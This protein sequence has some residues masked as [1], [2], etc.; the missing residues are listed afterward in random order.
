MI[1]SQDF[2]FF[3]HILILLVYSSSQYYEEV[4]YEVQELDLLVSQHMDGSWW[5]TETLL[6]SSN[7][8]VNGSCLPLPDYQ[9]QALYDLYTSTNGDNWV[10][11]IVVPGIPWNFTTTPYPD[12]CGDHW[13]GLSCNICEIQGI[14]LVEMNLD[15]TLPQSIGQFGSQLR[16]LT[17]IGNPLLHGTIPSTIGNL[18]HLEALSLAYSQLSGSFPVEILNG[19]VTNLTVILLGNNA[20]TGP[21]PSLGWSQLTQLKFLNI[22]NNSFSGSIPIE[23]FH[24]PSLLHINAGINKLVGS[25][26]SNIS[27]LSQ[28]IAVEF[29][30]NLLEGSLPVTLTQ[31]TQLQ[32]LILDDNRLTGTVFSSI[33]Q[34]YHLQYLVLNT[35][36]F[37]GT[38]PASL[39]SLSKLQYLY[40]YN[41]HFTGSLPCFGASSTS[42]R[43]FNVFNNH[44]SGTLPDNITLAGGMYSF[45]IHANRFTGSLPL[46]LMTHNPYL[47]LL[48]LH[49][50]M[51]TG[52]IPSL[53]NF[54]SLIFSRFDHNLFTGLIPTGL[55]ATIRLQLTNF[56]YNHLHGDVSHTDFANSLVLNTIDLSWNYFTGT[57]GNTFSQTKALSRL[58]LQ[59]NS[60]S[61]VID[62]LFDFQYQTNLTS[63][64]VSDNALEGTIPD[65]FFTQSNLS[66][67]LASTNCF[68]AILS[69]TMCSNPALTI[70]IMDG[71]HTAEQCRTWI[72]PGLRH[73]F[74]NLSAYM[75]RDPVK[76]T[77]PTCLFSLPLLQ[78]LHLSGNGI[79]STLPSTLTIS[80]SL[81]DLSLSHN[82]LVGTIPSPLLDYPWKTLDLSFNRLTGTISSTVNNF[83]QGSLTLTI[84]R[85]SGDIPSILYHTEDISVLEG[86]L[87]ACP[88]GKQQL[89]QHDPDLLAYVCGSDPVNTS[90]YIW[91]GI[92]S[93]L[94]I[95]V[96]LMIVLTI[97]LNRRTFQERSTFL[98]RYRVCRMLH[99]SYHYM[100]V[101]VLLWWQVYNS[102]SS[103]EYFQQSIEHI[104]EY[105]AVMKEI[106]R[107]CCAVT[108][109][110]VVIFLP[111]YS[112]LSIYY[113]TYVHAY[114]WQLSVAFLSGEIPAY[115]VLMGMIVFVCLLFSIVFRRHWM[116]IFHLYQRSGKKMITGH[117]NTSSSSIHTMRGVSPR[118]TVYGHTPSHTTTDTTA[119]DQPTTDTTTTDTITIAEDVDDESVSTAYPTNYPYLRW[120]SILVI[121][122]LCNILIVL[123]VNISYILYSTSGG[124]SSQSKQSLSFIIT[125]FKIG[126][127][128]TV[129]EVFQ[130]ILMKL[131]PIRLRQ[132]VNNVQMDATHTHGRTH[133]Q[134]GHSVHSSDGT[135]IVVSFMVWMNLFNNIIAPVIAVACVS[136]DCF[137]YAIFS[138]SAVQASFTFTECDG[139]VIPPDQRSI[140]CESYYPAAYQSDYHPAFTYNYQC[141]SS[142]LTNFADVMIYRFVITGFVTP[143]LMIVLKYV[144]EEVYVRYGLLSK[145]YRIVAV[146]IPPVLTALSDD[147]LKRR[148]EI[149]V[150]QEAESEKSVGGVEIENEGRE[151]EESVKDGKGSV[152][153][154]ES[155]EN[156]EKATIGGTNDNIET[157]S[158]VIFKAKSNIIAFISDIAVLLTF[159]GIF[160]PLAFIGFCGICCSTLFTQL[161]LARVV[162]LSRTQEAL[163]PSVERINEKCGGIRYIMIR[164]LLSLTLLLS[165]FWSFFLF[166]ILGDVVG[167]ARATWIITTMTTIPG[168]I[169]LTNYL[170]Q[171]YYPDLVV[172]QDKDRDDKREDEK[173]DI[174][175]ASVV[176]SNSDNS[177]NSNRNNKK[178]NEIVVNVLHS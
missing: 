104:Y 135:L 128:G 147:A 20:L 79:D 12:P 74:R 171:R 132:S 26:P 175:L 28:L 94:C 8:Y 144:Q 169:T 92:F 160:P 70:L 124:L 37:H 97:G 54:T 42:I 168:L 61:G 167:I 115:I 38:I 118:R 172:V 156:I 46:A 18:T 126:W 49:S 88:Q 64:D 90:I 130:G 5:W 57:L 141:T 47:K 163:R 152:T 157:I 58:L 3:L 137:Y 23:W 17:I 52:T 109:V 139:Y 100:E 7:N 25:L 112:I 62:N 53:H 102:K 24:L 122:G 153:N 67:F 33:D 51:L 41:N 114:T 166:D 63:V 50:N 55:T 123:I 177:D 10:Y 121:G 44:L 95:I 59:R 131:M 56:S 11:G 9:L 60:F 117:N 110:I 176:Y 80:P 35:N 68:H 98:S 149:V 161:I 76:G 16:A 87:Y 30:T 69:D 164:A 154:H 174:E 15:G 4:E 136:P 134:T 21:I 75:L 101:E 39:L 13:A 84:N 1:R 178:E 155:V 85:L 73:T 91:L 14:N 2:S 65:A 93:T 120:Y 82:E 99:A 159:G 116:N 96:L 83:T 40:L 146:L 66:V 31:L 72:F 89:P 107:W 158:K 151:N 148:R 45:D 34:L 129:M 173:K 48:Y 29:P 32:R 78:T 27:S 165:I 127:N 71:L 113:S 86:N 103:S 150:N 36:G 142:L 125:L 108:L 162:V 145:W 111:L 140:S 43:F 143:L 138:A 119:T 19:M 22:E 133:V 105:G 77:I 6:Q 81:Q 170:Y 106:R